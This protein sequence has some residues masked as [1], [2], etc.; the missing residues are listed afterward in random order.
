MQ[1]DAVDGLAG[2]A[3]L[4]R[5]GDLGLGVARRGLGRSGDKRD[6]GGEEGKKLTHGASPFVF[7]SGSCRAIYQC[8]SEP[9]LTFNP[10]SVH[11][12]Q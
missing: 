1:V 8:P 5:L 10:D 9:G 7:L 6:T 4:D 3:A 12:Q 2:D 11:R